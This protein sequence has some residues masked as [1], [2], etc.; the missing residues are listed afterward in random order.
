MNR[1]DYL[2]PRRCGLAEPER[3]VDLVCFHYQDPDTHD[4][5]T[6]DVI[7]QGD[8]MDFESQ[9][10]YDLHLN[11]IAC[12]LAVEFPGA[13]VFNT[14]IASLRVGRHKHPDPYMS[15]DTAQA[16]I[17]GHGGELVG[18]INAMYPGWISRHRDDGTIFD[19]IVIGGAPLRP[20][21]PK[22]AQDNDNS[23]R[24][25]IMMVERVSPFNNYVVRRIDVG[26][27]YVDQWEACKPMW[28]T[29]VLC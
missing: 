14:T 7:E 17:D 21:T 9:V 29:V 12:E 13:L 20:D 8:I 25:N 26:Y 22:D 28:E 11:P 10:I 2:W 4:L 3:I 5:R 23:W 18:W 24:L 1:V 19:F 16:S 27:A 15:D 6:L